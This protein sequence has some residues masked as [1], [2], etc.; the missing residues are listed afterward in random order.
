MIK[1]STHLYIH[2]LTV[3]FFACC[4]I[5]RSLGFAASVYAV[6][7]LHEAA[8]ALAA[9]YLGIGIS[10]FVLYPFGVN[11]KIKTRLL[12]SVADEMILYLSGPLV[13]AVAAL[14]C[15]VLGR[16]SIFYYNNLLLFLINILP[17]LPLDGGQAARRILSAK[18]GEEKATGL[19]SFFGFAVG[20]GLIVIMIKYS[21]LDI[22]S[23][24]F[25]LFL[26]ASIFT[27]K[28]KYSRD[29]VRELACTSQRNGVSKCD[30][31]IAD[32]ASDG[33]KILKKVVP[34]RG[35][36]VFFINENSQIVKTATDKELAKEILG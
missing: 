19:L 30:V 22:N 17:I 5:T 28:E 32:E 6:M 35:A 7:L 20:V 31:F 14:V 13:N 24:T 21:K 18:I 1:I 2:W 23:V 36:V 15:V 4:Y 11:L 16:K 3:A 12:A 26:I 10:R 8:H 34:S 29:F 27:C 25:A 33:V 9:M